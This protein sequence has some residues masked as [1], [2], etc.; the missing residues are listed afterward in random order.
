[1]LVF[2]WCVVLTGSRTG[3]AAVIVFG[4]LLVWERKNKIRNFILITVF[5]VVA[6]AVM[7]EQYQ[8][9]FLSISE[10]VEE[11]DDGSG[12]ATSAH[13]RLVFLG[14]AF[15]MFLD[16][17]IFGYGLGNFST[18]MGTIYGSLWLQAHSLPAQLISEM[19]LT[20]IIMF[21]TWVVFMF[22]HIKR[23]KLYFKRTGN[24]FFYNMSLALK[25]HIFLLLVMGLGGHNLFRYNWYI[26]SA[27]IV[28]MLNPQISGFGMKSE[29]NIIEDNHTFKKDNAKITE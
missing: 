22:G 28:M 26:I 25:N 12:A 16:R 20:G 18:A 15:E 27:I 5:L 10:V 17:P 29:G 4:L 9:R 1:M 23:F 6:V 19:G 8:Q 2:L 13:S 3:M 7:P 21:V 14:Y 11:T 24:I